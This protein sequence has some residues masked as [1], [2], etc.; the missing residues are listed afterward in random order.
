M[1]PNHRLERGLFDLVIIDEASQCSLATALPLVYRA[2]RLAV[3]G[4]PELVR[5]IDLKLSG[6]F[7]EEG[8]VVVAVGGGD[9]AALAREM[10]GLVAHQAVDLHVLHDPAAIPQR[11]VHAAPAIG[12]H[13]QPEVSVYL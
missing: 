6:A 13:R 10:R 5:D 3:I 9:K 2:K 4:D 7:Q 12:E 8:F 1:R 11:R